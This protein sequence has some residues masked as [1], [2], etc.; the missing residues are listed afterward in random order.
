MREGFFYEN[1]SEGIGGQIRKGKGKGRF[2]RG[3]HLQRLIFQP[4]FV[5]SGLVSSKVVFAA[6]DK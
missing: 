3:W 4:W 1:G 2:K 6:K 5:L